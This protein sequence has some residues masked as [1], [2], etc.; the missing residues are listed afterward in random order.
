LRKQVP[1]FFTFLPIASAKDLVFND[2][3]K[4]AVTE[5]I[6]GRKR[7]NYVGSNVNGWTAIHQGV[8]EFGV[9]FVRATKEVDGDTYIQE[10]RLNTWSGKRV[11]VD[12]KR[13]RNT[14]TYTYFIVYLDLLEAVK[15]DL[16][17]NES[18]NKR[19]EGRPAMVYRLVNDHLRLVFKTFGTVAEAIA[20]M[21]LGSLA[22][23]TPNGVM[24]EV[25]VQEVEADPTT[26]QVL[27]AL[28]GDNAHKSAR[29][30]LRW[31]AQT[32]PPEELP[33]EQP[34]QEQPPQVQPSQAP[35]NE[36]EDEPEPLIPRAEVPL[37]APDLDVVIVPDDEWQTYTRQ[38]NEDNSIEVDGV[39]VWKDTGLPVRPQG[40]QE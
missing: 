33:P 38:P 40:P 15:L 25:G 11:P 37:T 7:V 39:L 2:P 5:Q 35:A 34:S 12:P 21:G 6:M 20:M 17:F 28:L 23:T 27:I 19:V 1:R 8:N 32:M 9:E 13:L 30:L 10:F 14:R 26:L 29:E 36:P 24:N 4:T 3:P 31:T 18:P 16:P 22:L